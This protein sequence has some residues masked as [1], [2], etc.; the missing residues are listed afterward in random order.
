MANALAP[1]DWSHVLQGVHAVVNCAGVLQDSG[2]EHTKMVHTTA[3]AAL[4][5]ACEQAGVRRV[6]HFSAIGV[7]REQPSAFSASRLAGDETLTALDLDWI[8]LRP[9][10]GERSVFASFTHWQARSCAQISGTSP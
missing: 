3:A 4:F 9:S 5:R 2:R 10:P 7:D 1:D 6:I 8:I